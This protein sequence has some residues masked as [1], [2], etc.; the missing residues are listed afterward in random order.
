V[1]KIKRITGAKPFIEDRVLCVDPGKW[2]DLMHKGKY[3]TASDDPD[4][5]RFFYIHEL[6]GFYFKWRFT[7]RA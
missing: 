5:S 2:G 4:D 6:G 7:T 1:R 3:Y